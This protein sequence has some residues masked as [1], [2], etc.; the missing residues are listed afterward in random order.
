MNKLEK[1]NR[2]LDKNNEQI[3]NL[4]KK[5]SELEDF[6]KEIIEQ[7]GEA[8]RKEFEKLMHQKNLSYDDLIQKI[9]QV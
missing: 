8:K 6:R 9:Q 5:I 1:L 2:S 3:R 7:I 4:K